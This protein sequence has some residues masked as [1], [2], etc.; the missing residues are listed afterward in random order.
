MQK[1][2][3]PSRSCES[4]VRSDFLKVV[5]EFRYGCEAEGFETEIP[6]G[7]IALLDWAW[8]QGE[9]LLMC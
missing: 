9:M 3:Q 8:P 1:G 6:S 7:V 4:W 5:I 2:L